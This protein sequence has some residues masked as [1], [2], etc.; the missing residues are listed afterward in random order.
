MRK[1]VQTLLINF[2]L[3]IYFLRRPPT[4]KVYEI[5]L[6]QNEYGKFYHLLNLVTYD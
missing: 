4:P 3:F 2:Y 1:Y 5:F 6:K